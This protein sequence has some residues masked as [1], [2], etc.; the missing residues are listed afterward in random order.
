MNQI[1][2]W[3][4]AY[5][6]FYLR[7]TQKNLDNWEWWLGFTERKTLQLILASKFSTSKEEVFLL[8]HLNCFL[9]NLIYTQWVPT[10]KYHPIWYSF[11]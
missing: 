11:A 8:H 4:S 6:Y 3:K 1:L 7:E 5:I 10:L 9:E 2:D